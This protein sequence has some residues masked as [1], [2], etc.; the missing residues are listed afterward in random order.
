MPATRAKQTISQLKV[1]IQVI[2]IKVY[3]QNITEYIQ[4]RTGE[5][6]LEQSFKLI[7]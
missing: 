4:M 7:S 5:K 1:Q 6:H 2:S 3:N